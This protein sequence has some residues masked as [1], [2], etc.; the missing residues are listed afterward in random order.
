MK[1]F[2]ILIA[3]AATGAAAMLILT[4]NFHPIPKVMIKSSQPF[5]LEGKEWHC[6]YTSRQVDIN[7]LEEQIAKLKNAN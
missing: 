2:Y 4:I 5:I 3:G 6:A 1:N 7:I